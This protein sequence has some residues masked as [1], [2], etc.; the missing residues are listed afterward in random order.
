MLTAQSDV[1]TSST[2]S[3]EKNCRGMVG[4]NY[5]I[6]KTIEIVKPL[7]PDF[8]FHINTSH[9][10]ICNTELKWVNVQSSECIN[11]LEWL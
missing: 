10:M 1:V 11:T 2:Y 3:K 6:Q 9:L 7:Q 4:K 5:N 8:A